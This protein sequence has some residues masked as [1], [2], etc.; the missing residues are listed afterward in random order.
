MGLS[1]G[2]FEADNIQ[3]TL[4]KSANQAKVLNAINT[5]IQEFEPEPTQIENEMRETSYFKQHSDDD[6]P[7]KK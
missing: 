2:R 5:Q 3:Q 6:G 1:T 4:S 7:P